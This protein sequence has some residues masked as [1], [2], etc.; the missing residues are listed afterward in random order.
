M[1]KKNSRSRLEKRDVEKNSRS[2]L[3]K[4]Y[5]HANFSLYSFFQLF[6]RNRFKCTGLFNTFRGLLLYKIHS[7]IYNMYAFS[8]IP[9]YKYF[10]KPINLEH[11]TTLDCKC[12]CV[13]LKWLDESASEFWFRNTCRKVKS[14]FWNRFELLS[15]VPEV[16]FYFSP[17]DSESEFR[18]QYI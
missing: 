11:G 17:C 7:R 13:F 4:R 15:S 14:G 1:L 10:W 6:R 8:Y 5:F 18:G 9:P 12:K 2:R 3:E 16:Q